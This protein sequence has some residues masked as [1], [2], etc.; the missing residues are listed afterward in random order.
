LS[1]LCETSVFSTDFQKNTPVSGFMKIRLV[2][3]KYFHME[4]RR[5]MSK[6]IVSL[7]NCANTPEKWNT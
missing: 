1:D 4:R 6:L 2:G 7:H 5:D 3:A